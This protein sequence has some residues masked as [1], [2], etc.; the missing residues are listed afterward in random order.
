MSEERAI[1]DFLIE[2]QRLGYVTMV[3]RDDGE[4]GYRITPAGVAHMQEVLGRPQN[5]GI[6]G[7]SANSPKNRKIRSR[8]LRKKS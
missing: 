5:R 8:A 2:L 3:L 4:A 6:L 7:K 1:L